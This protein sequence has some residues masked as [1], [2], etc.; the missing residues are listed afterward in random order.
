MCFESVLDLRQSLF[1]YT[2]QFPLFPFVLAPKLM[3]T[4]TQR[5]L[6]RRLPHSVYLKPRGSTFTHR[7]QE[8]ELQ[9]TVTCYTTPL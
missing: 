8:A 2:S 7:Q 9:S 1:I 6:H 4:S 5:A 3:Y